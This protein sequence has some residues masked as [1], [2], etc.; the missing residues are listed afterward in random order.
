MS[1]VTCTVLVLLAL[2]TARAEGQRPW[3]ADPDGP[4]SPSNAERNRDRENEERN[5]AIQK[6]REARWQQPVTLPANPFERMPYIKDPEP[7]WW[8][9]WWV[10][11]LLII[12]GAA[13]LGAGGLANRRECK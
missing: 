7:P 11:D 13:A 10:K 4:A 1:R 3:F 12:G 2:T 6:A 8:E 5:R 9:K